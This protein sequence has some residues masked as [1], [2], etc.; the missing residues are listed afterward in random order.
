[1][2][3]KKAYPPKIQNKLEFVDAIVLSQR[4]EPTVIPTAPPTT[5]PVPVTIGPTGQ[6]EAVAS[7][8][9]E[10][11]L[12]AVVVVLSVV[13]LV[14][15]VVTWHIRRKLKDAISDPGPTTRLI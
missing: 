10:N 4:P 12:I 14:L 8:K 5:E 13:V 6:K 7:K 9:T 2:L 11:A 15:V 1:M 3:S